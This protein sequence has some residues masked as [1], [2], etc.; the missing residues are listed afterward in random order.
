M[1]NR[2]DMGLVGYDA[3]IIQKHSACLKPV[4]DRYSK[5]LLEYSDNL[6]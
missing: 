5:G 4:F 1:F 3:N 6:I 2:Y